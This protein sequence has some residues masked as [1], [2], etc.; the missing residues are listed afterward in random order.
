M[1]SCDVELVR[2]CYYMCPHTTICVLIVLCRCAQTTTH[3]S[4]YYYIYIHTPTYLMHRVNSAPGERKTCI[5]K[6]QIHTLYKKKKGDT[7][8]FSEDTYKHTTHTHTHTHTHTRD[9]ERARAHT[10]THT[11]S[12]A[13]TYTASEKGQPVCSMR[14]YIYTS[15]RTTHIYQHENT[16]IPV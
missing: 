13:C 4:S 7:W 3:V 15:M 10:H 6:Q 9:H 11:N 2:C 16:Y 12:D 5:Q 8:P 14:T 1:E